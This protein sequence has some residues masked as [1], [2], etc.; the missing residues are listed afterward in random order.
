MAPSDWMCIWSEPGPH[1]QYTGIISFSRLSQATSEVDTGDFMWGID[2]RCSIKIPVWIPSSLQLFQLLQSECHP[3]PAIVLLR[4]EEC[5]NMEGI[6]SIF[7]QVHSSV[8]TPVIMS[9]RFFTCINGLR[10]VFEAPYIASIL[11]V[12]GLV[13]WDIPYST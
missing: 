3:T 12:T 6:H 8:S 7:I 11:N 4:Q 2:S 1:F 9:S 5:L 10:G 13:K